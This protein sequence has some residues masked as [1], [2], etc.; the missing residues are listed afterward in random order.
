MIEIDKKLP[1]LK[2]FR[3]LI[4]TT[5]FSLV[6]LLLFT[7]VSFAQNPVP[8][9]IINQIRGSEDCCETG[10]KDMI[11][12]IN[13]E[14]K[15]AKLSLAWALRFDALQSG[16]FKELL[17]SLP[18]NQPLGILLEVTPQ[19][20]SASA[21]IYK[22]NQN[23]GDW[24]SSRN[25]FLTGYSI[26]ERKKLVDTV[27]ETFYQTFRYYPNFTVGWMIDAWSLNYLQKQYG[28]RVHEITKEQ[29]ETDNYTL[30]GGLFNFPYFPSRLHPIIPAWHEF[31]DLLIVR[32]TI[33]D[34]EK[35]YGSYHSY[36][37]SQ[38]NDYASNPQKGNFS[39]FTDLLNEV[40][41]QEEG[42]RFALVGLE[43]SK[44]WENY[45]D[46]YLKQLDYL[47]GKVEAGEYKAMTPFEYYNNYQDKINNSKF[48][49][50]GGFPQNGVGW[51]FTDKY[52]ARLEIWD[53]KLVLTD[54][55]I[56]V[57]IT[58][59]YYNEP[60]KLN[61]GYWIIP[62]ALDSSQQ[63]TV[64]DDKDIRFK[65]NPIR[66]DEAVK[67]FGI[68]LT[69]SKPKSVKLEDGNL[70]ISTDKDEVVRL[71]NDLIKIAKNKDLMLAD[72]L[73]LGINEILLQNKT[74][75]FTFLRHPRYFIE[76]SQ[77]KM[78]IVLGWE[79]PEEDKIPFLSIK[80]INNDWELVPNNTLSEIQLATLAEIFQ[81]D[82]SSLRF[83]PNQSTFY[84]HNTEAIAGRNPVRLL[85]DARNV[86]NRSVAV[87]SLAI[88][89]TKDKNILIT[90]PKNIDHLIEPFFID[91]TASQSAESTITLNVDGNIIGEKK[92]IRFYADCTKKLTTCLSN[93]NELTGFTRIIL[94]EKYGQYL[95]NIEILVKGVKQKIKTWFVGL[96]LL[97]NKLSFEEVRDL[98]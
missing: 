91:F 64:I 73:N 4:L 80:S 79:N 33:S 6:P 90:Q 60:S 41:N 22:G 74:S 39:Y 28:V 53:D 3:T 70:I 44:E 40:K 92:D 55:R 11:S 26:D 10:T 2:T 97:K 47:A 76:P 49:K 66:S 95:N 42:S 31:L 34:L 19:L 77:E 96:P 87:T 38:P 25:A 59:P 58:D 48:L 81:P 32:Q 89:Q 61:H 51:Y 27:F 52:R 50:T 84:W 43:N 30:Y 35:N 12:V 68:Y 45:Q 13:A 88:S 71:E 1:G 5:C 46:E 8:L 37:T 94:K 24:R 54:L 14:E 20:A 78:E 98:S 21:V 56:F 16:E 85:I 86:L 29:Y 65:G 15:R 67:R 75:Y 18:K 9:L 62:Y 7:K 69:Q 72:P 36:Y 17:L 57:P 83:E 63:F 82:R 23:Y 93:R